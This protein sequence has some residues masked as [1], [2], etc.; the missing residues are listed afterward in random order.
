MKEKNEPWKGKYWWTSPYNFVPEVKDKIKIDEIKIN[1]ETLRDGEQ[2][3]GVVFK[4]EERVKIVE[5]LDEIGIDRIDLGLPLVSKEDKKTAKKIGSL[6]LNAEIICF[7]RSIT[8]DVDH[9]I[10]CG[11]DG[12]MCEFPTSKDLIEQGYRWTIEEA[13]EKSTS[14][15]QYAKE[16]GIKATSFFVDSTRSEPELLQY[17]LKRVSEVKPDSLCF[18]DTFG[19]LTPISTMHFINKIKEWIKIPIEVHFHDNFGMAT[20]NSITAL[21]NGAKMVHT[22]ING[23]GE[24]A[25]M[26]PLDE[27][28]LSLYLLY[29][30]NLDIHYNKLYKLSKLVEK[31]SG[32]DIPVS[33]PIIGKDIFT[34]ES[35]LLVSILLKLKEDNLN[36]LVLFPFT[37]ELLNRDE[38]DVVLGK[39]SGKASIKYMLDKL[40][41]DLKKELIPEVLE[42]VKVLGEKK[43]GLLTD[44]EF[45]EIVI[46]VKEKSCNI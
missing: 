8:S 3:P 9:A 39:K 36:P 11:V 42:E 40:N 46:R 28:A 24:G 33:K 22:T 1:D 17:I 10:D 43:K 7:S 19:V 31:F 26:P 12:V 21:A 29:G 37:W 5:M 23:M 18:A 35:G 25:G 34:I 41:I 14:T 45:K 30:V 2:Q 4:G 16:H 32:I 20:A 15:I 44:E 6:G 38:V 13:I 27:V